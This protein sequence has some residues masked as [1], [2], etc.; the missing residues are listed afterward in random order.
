MADAD[1]PLLSYSARVP[2]GYDKP[3]VQHE[4]PLRLSLYTRLYFCDVPCC[5][6]LPSVI[7]LLLLY[8]K[9]LPCLCC[10]G[11]SYPQQYRAQQ[12]PG[13]QSHTAP[14]ATEAFN[15][16]LCF[17]AAVNYIFCFVFKSV[18]RRHVGITHARQGVYQTHP[19]TR[20]IMETGESSR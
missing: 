15:S 17:S 12:P 8:S 11:H 19:S 6:S 3:C 13:C 9:F 2:G 4:I 5:L 1:C 7:R 16:L 10:T 20:K 14:Q 18:Y